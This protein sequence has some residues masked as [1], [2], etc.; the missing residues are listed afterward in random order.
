MTGSLLVGA[1]YGHVLGAAYITAIAIG[2]CAV[3]WLLGW[4]GRTA[5]RPDPHGA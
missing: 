2:V 3:M 5:F 1:S 4:A